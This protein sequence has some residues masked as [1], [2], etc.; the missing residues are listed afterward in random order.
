[1][2]KRSV[3][4]IIIAVVLAIL[5]AAPLYV[6][7]LWFQSA[8][9]TSVFTTQLLAQLA[10]GFAGFLVVFGLLYGNFRLFRRFTSN[11]PISITFTSEGQMVRTTIDQPLNRWVKPVAALI[12]LLG[13][14]ALAPQWKT[15]LLYL[16]QT[17][18]GR[19]DPVLGRE[20]SFYIF[21]MPFWQVVLGLLSFV[22]FLALVGTVALYVAQG[23]LTIRRGMKRGLS[24]L[25]RDMVSLGRGAREHIAAL[26]AI[27]FVLSALRVYLVDMPQLLLGSGGPLYGAGFTAANVRLPYLWILLAG[28]V[29]G[30]LLSLWAMR[31]RAVQKLVGAMGLYIGVTV[32]GGWLAPALVQALIVQ[33]N[34]LSKERPYIEHHITATQRAWDIENVS[35]KQLSGEA[36]LTMQDIRENR[37]TINNIRLWDREPL[38]ST[39]GQLQEIRTYYDFAD[40]DNDRYTVNGNYRQVMLSPRELNSAALPNRTFVNEHLSFTHGM[41]VAAAPVNEVTQEGLPKL[42]TKDLPPTSTSETLNIDRPQLYYGQ[43]TDSFALVNTRAQEFDYPKGDENVYTDYTGSGGVGIGSF[44]RRALFA[45]Q[46]GEGKILFSQDLTNDSKILFRRTIGE[47]V[48]TAL[49]FL[50]FDSD[51]Y[52]VVHNGELKWIYDAYTS[53]SQYPYSQPVEGDNYMRNSV[54]VV[55]DAYDGTIDAY[56]AEP[57]DPIIRTYQKIFPDVFQPLSAMSDELKSHIRYPEDLFAKQARLYTLY[58]MEEPN[59]F[60][61]QEDKW[62]IP[63]L[64]VTQ[65]GTTEPIMR[66]LIMELP[67]S[68]R[69]EF[70][71]MLPFTPQRKDNMTAWLAARSDGEQYGELVAYEFPKQRLI[72]G[73]QQIVGRINQDTKISRQISLWDQRGSRAIQ[74]NLYVIPIEESIIYVRPLYL[75]SEGGQIPQLKRVILAY[76]DTIVMAPTLD[77]ALRRV[78]GAGSGDDSGDE[79]QRSSP[80]QPGAGGLSPQ[81]RQLLQQAREAFR[82]AQQAQQD[83]NWS[84]YG[85]NINRLG[86]ILDQLRP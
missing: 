67:G 71:L 69:E 33:P 76:K 78:F 26:F 48:R 52:I 42:L 20:I 85:D 8:G 9:L 17:P 44:L 62:D 7:W 12:G 4:T 27:W 45:W 56:V 19:S 55:V 60:Y 39:L 43:L 74:G 6:D 38:L 50:Q 82:S 75:Q 37:A 86:D 68:D 53:A 84:A 35:E 66:H 21:S 77:E 59:V 40:V 79:Q 51:P 3:I 41:G 70:I 14:L 73:P 63:R 80:G 28:L 32:I 34:E 1:M 61:N 49:P 23:T 10:V 72:F 58:H 25:W 30:A 31:G 64:G 47:R 81:Q 65:R 13:A 24:A 11:A 18:F 57:K 16:N 54:K 5:A 83:G 15:V 36:T 2:A 22:L 46:M 29:L